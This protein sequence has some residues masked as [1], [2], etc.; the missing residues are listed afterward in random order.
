MMLL[1][2]VLTAVFRAKITNAAH[3]CLA[4]EYRNNNI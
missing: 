3:D 4:K 2:F 1:F